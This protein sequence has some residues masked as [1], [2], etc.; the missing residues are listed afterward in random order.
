MPTMPAIPLSLGLAALAVLAAAM[1]FAVPNVWRDRDETKLYARTVTSSSSAQLPKD[2]AEALAHGTARAEEA[3]DMAVAKSLHRSGR[4]YGLTLLKDAVSPKMVQLMRAD[5]L[6]LHSQGR[7]TP[8]GD[9][10][11][12]QLSEQ[13][14]K[15]LGSLPVLTILSP[16]QAAD[17][18]LLGLAYGG[19]FLSGLCAQLSEL[20]GKRLVPGTLQRLDLGNDASWFRCHLV[21]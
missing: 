18:G 16:Q 21:H 2:A 4:F 12:P 20:A 9:P 5:S 17:D 14:K 8:S 11:E 1:A 15:Y 19:A 6:K 7:L 3:I 10:D 13:Y